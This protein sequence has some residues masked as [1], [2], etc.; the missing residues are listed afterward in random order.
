MTDKYF[1]KYYPQSTFRKTEAEVVSKAPR[2]IDLRLEPIKK[3][4]D[5]V[6]TE[7]RKKIENTFDQISTGLL[8]EDT[9]K[10]EDKKKY[11]LTMYKK[12]DI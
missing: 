11:L 1:T 7:L 2:H 3:L 6:K 12:L 10:I 9:I 5:K 4:N 8:P